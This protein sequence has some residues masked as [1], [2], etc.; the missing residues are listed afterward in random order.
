MNNF[1]FGN[2]K[3]SY[4]ETIGGGAGATKNKKGRSAIHQHMTNT[5]ITDPEELEFRYPVI[6][7]K[8]EIRK[9]SGGD[10]LN[11]G[12]DGITRQLKF[13]EPMT[14]TI[15]AQHRIT[16]PYGMNDG[17]AG[18]CGNQFLLTSLKKIKLDANT[19]VK[20]EAGDSILI[21]TPG[22]GGWGKIK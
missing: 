21:N 13:L 14:A 16:P 17:E 15:I 10:G 7:D 1:L 12:G 6:L 9:N 5:K 19:N 22:G 4:Y 3:Y 20:V 11:K 8:F 2:N 18:S